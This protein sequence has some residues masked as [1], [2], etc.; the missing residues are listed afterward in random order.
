M[1]GIQI[2]Y[3]LRS[4]Q[5]LSIDNYSFESWEVSKYPVVGIETLLQNASKIWLYENDIVSHMQNLNRGEL[6]Y[7]EK[8]GFLIPMVRWNI[9]ENQFFLSLVE[10]N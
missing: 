7:Q 8:G 10:G 4:E 6:V 1:L 9:K 2:Q 5:I 3:H